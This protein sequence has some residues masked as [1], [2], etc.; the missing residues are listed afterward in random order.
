MKKTSKREDCLF[1]NIANKNIS[2][3][4]IYE[5]ETT[6]AF[7][8]INQSHIGHTLVIPKQHVCN[9]LNANQ[10]QIT[11]VFKAVKK[12]SNYY[13]NCGFTGI[14]VMIANGQ[15]SGQTVFH[16]HVH[17]FPCGIKY[18]KKISTKQILEMLKIKER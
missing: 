6:L 9:L 16:L 13:L 3:N 4:I 5:N 14:K 2:S 11:E 15:S 12:V 10:K 18:D 1:C 17:I 7:L 8:D